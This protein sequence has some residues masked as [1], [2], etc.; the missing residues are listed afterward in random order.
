MQLSLICHAS[1]RA[2][3]QAA[4][5]ADEP[6]DAIGEA[7]AHAL[8]GWLPAAAQIWRSTALRAQQ[9][10]TALA[11]DATPDRALD[12]C[13]YG[14]WAGRRL[15]ELQEAEPAAIGAWLQDPDALPHGGESIAAMRQRVSRWMNGLD[16]MADHVIAVTHASVIRLVILEALDA[17]S[18]SFWRIDINPLS[19][20]QL[21]FS[22]HR[23]T[24][25]SS[26]GA[27]A[28]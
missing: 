1:T 10:A 4:F 6:I 23:W 28:V 15:A 2:L 27:M 21:R 16:K 25:V 8:A 11:L 9:T 24:L 5:P 19:L 12:D 20:T 7:K 26:G 3:R 22:Q 17:K 18:E 14:R 13:D